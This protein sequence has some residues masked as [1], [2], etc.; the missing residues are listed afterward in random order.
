[1]DRQATLILSKDNAYIPVVKQTTVATVVRDNIKN[2][3]RLQSEIYVRIGLDN[4]A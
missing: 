4:H 2:E 3:S 1:M